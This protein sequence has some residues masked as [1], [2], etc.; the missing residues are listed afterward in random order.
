MSTHDG[1]LNDKFQL[2]ERKTRISTEFRAALATFLTMCYI[3]L[4]NP[5]LLANVIGEKPEVVVVSTALSSA[6]GCFIAGFF[7]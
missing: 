5:Q 6:L 4:V 2:T 1:W 7:G 3:L